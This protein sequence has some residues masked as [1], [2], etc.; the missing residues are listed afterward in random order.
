[1]AG[2]YPLGE[3]FFEVL[4]MIALMESAEGWCDLQWTFTDFAD[5]MAARAVGLENNEAPLRWG[6][7]F[8][9]PCV[10]RRARHEHRKPGET[11]A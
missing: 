7:H 11:D 10:R 2:D 1:M 5:R 6:Q 9:A 8:V 3:R 4:N